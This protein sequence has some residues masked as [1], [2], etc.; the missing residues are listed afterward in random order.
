MLSFS[1]AGKGDLVLS[2]EPTVSC[3]VEKSCHGYRHKSLVV[4]CVVLQELRVLL[5]S[6]VG[7]G[8][9]RRVFGN[10][11]VGRLVPVPSVPG[12]SV[13]AVRPAGGTNPS[14]AEET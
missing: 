11:R 4:S 9:R 5:C 1:K 6:L 10:H 14:C 7:T 12:L 8:L 13:L 3:F 2:S